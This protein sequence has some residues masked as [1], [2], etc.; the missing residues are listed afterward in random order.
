M[1]MSRTYNV[2]TM[3]SGLGG[4]AK[5]FQRAQSRVGNMTAKWRCIGGIDNDPAAVVPLDVIDAPDQRR[6][7]RAGWAAQHDLLAFPDL[8]IDVVEN[9]GA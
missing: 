3:C 8:Q 7:P 6:L 9:L 5:G 1:D 2:F 4:G